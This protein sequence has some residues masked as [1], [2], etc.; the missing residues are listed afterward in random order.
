MSDEFKFS[1]NLDAMFC[2]SNFEQELESLCYQTRMLWIGRWDKI[3][4]NEFE[5]YLWLTNRFLDVPEIN[6]NDIVVNENIFINENHKDLSDKL[7][8]RLIELRNS[9]IIPKNKS[10]WSKLKNHL[11]KK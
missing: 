8:N 5:F 7:K 11:K 1:E 6:L 9:K 10:L 4:R 2:K 3:N